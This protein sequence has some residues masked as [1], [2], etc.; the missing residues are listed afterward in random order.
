MRLDYDYI[1]VGMGA[2]GM[3]LAYYLAQTSFLDQKHILIL[4]KD[5]KTANNRTWTFWGNPPSPVNQLIQRTWRN[6]LVRNGKTVAKVDTSAM[7]YHYLPA[8]KFYQGLLPT[9]LAHPNITWV[10]ETVSGIHEDESAAYVTANNRTF[11]ATYVFNSAYPFTSTLPEIQD[12]IAYQRFRGWEVVLDKPVVEDRSMTLMDFALPHAKDLRFMYGLPLSHNR[13]IL[14]CTLFGWGGLT[15]EYARNALSQ[16]LEDYY[17][18][19]NYQIERYEG[20]AIPMSHKPLQRYWGKRIVNMGILGGDTRPSTGYTFLS[21]VRFAKALSQSLSRH[22]PWPNGQW[23]KRQRFYDRL[24]L[25][26]LA[27]NPHNLRRSLMAIFMNNRAKSIFRFMDGS[28]LIWEEVRLVLTL[29][30]TPF[31]KALAKQIKSKSTTHATGVL[32]AK[33]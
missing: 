7:P 28:S 26:V 16:Y 11:T 12:D 23:G 19:V 1:I 9:I 24:F 10:Q 5:D 3:S 15:E 27:D 14:N 4:E 22:K 20:G 2:A 33:G 32:P 31:L 18:G 25:Q 13:L 17:H 29:P 6:I 30:F 8:H 21:A